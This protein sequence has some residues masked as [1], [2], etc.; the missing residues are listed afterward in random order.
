MH[1]P[2][3]VSTQLTR[4]FQ[5]IPRVFNLPKIT[6]HPNDLIK[7]RICTEHDECTERLLWKS[8]DKRVRLLKLETNDL[9]Q[10][11]HSTTGDVLWKATLTNGL[12]K[13]G[14][15]LSRALVINGKSSTTH[16]TIWQIPLSS[17]P[18]IFQYTL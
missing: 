18:R 12:L 17:F 8:I 11:Y 2:W 3:N 9:T 16:H 6:F 14:N 4:N 13:H 5:C 1:H 7:F 15:V 10:S